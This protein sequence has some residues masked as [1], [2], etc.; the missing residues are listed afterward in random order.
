MSSNTDT[1]LVYACSGCSSAAQT[2]NA[3]A[4]RL[5]RHSVAEMSCIAGVGGDIPRFVQEARSGRVIIALDGCPIACAR[6]TLAR[7]GV[8]PAHHYD[9]SR[10]NVK[11]EKDKDP[12]LDVVRRIEKSIRKEHCP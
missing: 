4:I 3:L 1:P 12:D 5:D 8:A 7:H 10:F 9:L 6:M 11:R 2:A